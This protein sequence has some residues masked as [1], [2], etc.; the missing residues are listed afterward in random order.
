MRTLLLWGRRAAPPEARLVPGLVLVAWDETVREALRERGIETAATPDEGAQRLDAAVAEWTDA[1]GNAPLLEDRR[2]RDLLDWNGVSVWWWIEPFLRRQS[3]A[4]RYVRCIEVFRGLLESVTPDEVEVE[5]LSP[6]QTLLLSRTCVAAGVLFGD[7]VP[8]VRV[9]HGEGRRSLAARRIAGGHALRALGSAWRGAHAHAEPVPGRVLFLSDASASGTVGRAECVLEPLLAAVDATEDLHAESGALEA[10]VSL[11]VQRSFRA[12]SRR[13]RELW[14]E[15]RRLPAV[16]GAF[17]HA[18][19]RFDD[20][21]AADLAEMLLLRAPAAVRA[22]EL[23]RA[24]LRALA[25]VSVC[26]CTADEAWER[27]A[28]SACRSVGVTTIALRDPAL[29]PDRLWPVQGADEA[30]TYRADWTLPATDTPRILTLLRQ[31]A[32]SGRVVR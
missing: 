14:R 13:A 17:A 8:R 23:T 32:E 2:F 19:V 20:L 27:I 22:Y 6:E 3:L 16:L 7:E 15:L 1:W 9:S 18:G 12:A 10:H 25:P 11:E 28:A 24:T 5:G 26:L 21:A 31:T 30:G 4:A 29:H